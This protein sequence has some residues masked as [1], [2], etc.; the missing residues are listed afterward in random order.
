MKNSEGNH[1]ITRR[2]FLKLV[3]IT[4]LALTTGCGRRSAEGPAPAADFSTPDVEISITTR[5]V[6]WELA[7]GKVIQAWTYNG[8]V[9]GSTIR[10]RYGLQPWRMAVSLP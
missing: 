6:D 1:Q 2:E 9:P 10:I 4:T 8:Q 5:E 3:G 7:P